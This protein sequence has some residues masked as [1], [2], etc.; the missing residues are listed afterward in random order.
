MGL[1]MY[2]YLYC[3][4]GAE[5]AI[6]GRDWLEYLRGEA[7]EKERVEWDAEGKEAYLE[8]TE[9]DS[10]S[11]KLVGIFTTRWLLIDWTD[12]LFLDKKNCRAYYPTLE[13][14]RYR[15][16]YAKEKGIGVALWETGQ[17][18]DHFYNLL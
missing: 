16:D 4:S 15:L 7:G 12:A 14:I 18:L 9:I 11:G 5:K 3:G 2:G 10:Q 6:L 8:F 17:G 1:A 13:S